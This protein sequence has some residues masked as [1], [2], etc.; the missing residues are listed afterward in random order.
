MQIRS[1]TTKAVA[2]SFGLMS[3]QR[4]SGVSAVIYYTV[5]IFRGAG[6]T[7]DPTTATIAVGLSQVAAS[8]TSALLVD[9]LGR[10]F[11]LLLSNIVMALSLAV[12]VVYSSYREQ[13]VDME[14]HSWIPVVALCVFIAVFRVGLGPIPW[15]MMAELLPSEIKKWASSAVVCYTWCLTFLVTKI[16]VSVVDHL[17][18]SNT[19]LIMCTL[20]VVGV[21]FEFFCVPETKN[22]SS[23]EIR[24]ALIRGNFRVKYQAI[25][26]TIIED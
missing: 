10:R 19:Y 21:F 7:L 20:C 25:P 8:A 1:T 16:F 2:I 12:M 24:S 3:C 9:K 22:R 5:D 18:F 4:L 14:R 15:F 26:E 6:T 11:L 13:G 17:G 23:E